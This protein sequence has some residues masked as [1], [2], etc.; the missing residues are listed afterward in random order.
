M[1]AGGVTMAEKPEVTKMG[2]LSIPI[3]IIVL[4]MGALPLFNLKSTA[5]AAAIGTWLHGL[6]KETTFTL[7]QHPHLSQKQTPA[8]YI[9]RCDWWMA[10][11]P[12]LTHNAP[13]MNICSLGV[14]GE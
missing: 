10:L 6:A 7:A 4:G 13:L 8:H 2:L 5:E 1:L 3:R 12:R 11:V 9:T 14:Q